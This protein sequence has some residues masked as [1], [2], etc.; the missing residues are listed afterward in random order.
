MSDGECNGDN[1][2][3]FVCVCVC[4]CVCVWGGNRDWR[5][6]QLFHMGWSWK[7]LMTGCN[8]SKNPEESSMVEDLFSRK[9]LYLIKM[10][11]LFCLMDL[12]FNYLHTSAI[13]D[14]DS[15]WVTSTYCQI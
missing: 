12:Q 11:G 6:G 8:Y 9:W 2:A 15:S 14:C 10:G 4:V 3:S 7:I 13:D 5:W 1:K